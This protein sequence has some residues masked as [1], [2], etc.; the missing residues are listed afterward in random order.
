M[1]RTKGIGTL[2]RDFGCDGGD[3]LWIAGGHEE[4]RKKPK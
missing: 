2:T 1:K 4:L 3:E